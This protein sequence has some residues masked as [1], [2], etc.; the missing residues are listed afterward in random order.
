MKYSDFDE[1]KYAKWTDV[2]SPVVATIVDVCKEVMPRD[3]KTKLVI[4][5]TEEEFRFGVVLCK[6]TRQALAQITGSED[7]MDAI[8]TTVELYNDSTVRNPTTG[9]Y[10]AVRIRRASVRQQPAVTPP[11]KTQD[12][13]NAELAA[14]IS[15]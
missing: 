4:Y 11:T 14:E 7:P 12:E 9:E 13:I 5:F 15:Y 8:G 10:G 1:R 2:V 6:A 3:G